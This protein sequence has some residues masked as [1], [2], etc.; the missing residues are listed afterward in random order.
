MGDFC[1]TIL[2]TTTHMLL[3]PLVMFGNSE[4]RRVI[5]QPRVVQEL[6]QIRLNKQTLQIHG[7]FTDSWNF[8][9]WRAVHGS[10]STL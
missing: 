6:L 5:N 4:E 3:Q 2:K 1:H 9:N 10:L 8:L 7:I